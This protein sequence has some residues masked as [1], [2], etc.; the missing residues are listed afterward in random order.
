MQEKL[1]NDAEASY[2]IYWLRSKQVIHSP[3]ILFS[4][5]SNLKFATTKISKLKHMIKLTWR[6]QINLKSE[7]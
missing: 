1:K 5:N 4:L 6:H 3:F 2:I 7:Q